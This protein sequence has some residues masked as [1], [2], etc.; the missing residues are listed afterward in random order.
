M[1]QKHIIVCDDDEGI[2]D[3]AT[4]V[5]TEAGYFV[6]PLTKSS[7]IFQTIQEKRPHLILIDLWMPDMSGE[8]ITRNL[9]ENSDTKD[10]PIIII[11]A[12]KNTSDVAEKAGAN[13]FIDKPFD[14]DELE[15]VVKKYLPED[16]L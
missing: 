15:R 10:I 8:E 14:L 9:K 7:D 1:V 16:S 11:S 2:A 6:T 12:N 13:G 5:L 4:I 3:V